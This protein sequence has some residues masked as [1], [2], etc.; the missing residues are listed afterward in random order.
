MHVNAKQPQEI[1]R[2]KN[3]SSSPGYT[4]VWLAVT[5]LRLKQYCQNVKALVRLSHETRVL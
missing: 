2:E 4:C 5:T 3:N 1:S